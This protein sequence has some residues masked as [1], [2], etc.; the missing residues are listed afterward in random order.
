MKEEE[1]AATPGQTMNQKEKP[2]LADAS[3]SPLERRALLKLDLFIIPM[4][5]LC[6]FFSYLDRSNLGNVRIVGLQKDLQMSD[7]DF[8]MALT[9]TFM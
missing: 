8:S 2:G 5:T 3:T 7:Y 9:V 6:F 1:Q 4:V